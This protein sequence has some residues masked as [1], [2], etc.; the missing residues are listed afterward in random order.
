M[1]KIT[2]RE[3]QVISRAVSDPRRFE[4]LRYIARNSCAPCSDI[5]SQFPISAPTLSHHMKELE[6]AGLIDL[7]KRGKFVDATFRPGV[8]KCYLE[9]MNRLLEAPQCAG[10]SDS[11]PKAQASSQD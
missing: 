1:A 6:A 10:L 3:L 8:W 5:R 4:I 7:E 2:K 11:R 9:E